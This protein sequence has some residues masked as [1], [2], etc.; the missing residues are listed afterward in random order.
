MLDGF[1]CQVGDLDHLT[2]HESGMKQAVRCAASGIV[3]RQDSLYIHSQGTQ[4]SNMVQ[5]DQK[6]LFTQVDGYGSAVVT[7]HYLFVHSC[8]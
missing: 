1:C 8:S 2:I 4:R 6:L 5:P 3:H 7:W